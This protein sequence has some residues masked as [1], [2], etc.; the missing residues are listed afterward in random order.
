MR[1]FFRVLS[2]LFIAM[3][4]CSSSIQ[5]ETIDLEKS[6]TIILS[7]DEGADLQGMDFALYKVAGIEEIENE[8]YEYI[9]SQAFENA[10]LSFNDADAAQA[11]LLQQ[12]ERYIQKNGL[13]ADRT[14]YAKDLDLSQPD[15]LRFEDVEPGLYY[16]VQLENAQAAS[17]VSSML[18]S[19]PYESSYEVH[20]YLKGVQISQNQQPDTSSKPDTDQS[21]DQN[22]SGDT[23]DSKTED[24]I[25]FT[26]TY[27]YMLWYLILAGF[28]LLMLG[29]Y[30]LIDAHAYL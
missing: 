5:A 2:F 29:A 16:C 10:N 9:P 23:T 8:I 26:G 13:Q 6:G 12:V 24:E 28:G 17:L 7:S 22:T 27:Q 19:V 21:T 18:I 14:I 11:D 3:L 20:S 4:A 15:P 30:M 25:P 1:N